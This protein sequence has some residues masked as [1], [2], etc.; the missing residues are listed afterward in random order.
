MAISAQ[1]QIVAEFS[2]SVTTACNLSTIQFTDKSTGNPTEWFWDFGNGTTSTEQNPKV[3]FLTAGTFDIKL[4]AKTTTSKGI[5]EKKDY[6]KISPSPDIDFD[7]SPD[8]GCVSL[9][10]LFTNYTQTNGSK[11]KTWTWDFG[12]GTSSNAQNPSHVYNTAGKFDIMLTAETMDGCVAKLNLKEGVKAGQPGKAQFSATPLNGCRSVPRHFSDASSGAI[13]SWNW[14]FGDGGTSTEQN[15]DYKYM[16]TGTFTVKL[17]VFNNGCADSLEY[18]DYMHII[19]P[20]AR[21][22][23]E[24]NCADPYN[25]SFK[26]RSVG[27][28]T[29]QWDFGDGTT[30]TVKNPTHRFSSTGSYAVTL[31]VSNDSCTDVIRDTVYVIDQSPQVQVSSSKT[32]FCRLDTITFFINNYDTALVRSYAWDFDDGEITGFGAFQDTITHVYKESGVYRPR[33]F[34]R[35]KMPCIDTIPVAAIIIHGPE[36]DFTFQDSVCLG[37]TTILKTQISTYNDEPIVKYAWEYGDGTTEEVANGPF[38]HT[39]DFPGKYAIKLNVTD[40]NGCEASAKD[41]ITIFEHPV[42]SA[43]VDTMV[44]VGQSIKLSASGADSYKWDNNAALSCLRCESPVATPQ[45]SGIFYVTGSNK[46][47]CKTSDSVFVTVIQKQEMVVKADANRICEGN[48]IQ[49]NAVGMDI[50]Q[51]TPNSYLSNASVS[52]PVATP[53]MSTTYTVIGSDKLS[54][55]FD[56]VSVFIKVDRVPSINIVDSVITIKP[57]NTKII[58]TR[59]SQ[60]V[61]TWTWTPPTGLSCTDCA[62][63][64]FSLENNIIYT[65]Q[66]ENAAGCTAKDSVNVY[67]FCTKNSLFI[68]NT[69]SPNGDGMNDVFYPRSNV[70]VTIKSMRVFNKWGQPVYE[71]IN[72][73]SNEPRFG[74][75]GTNGS[76]KATTD[77]YLYV[78]DVI[79]SNGL[80]IR[81]T[82]TVTLLQ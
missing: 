11:I 72:I 58:N 57:G 27:D 56:T 70:P 45:G 49:L 24:V 59:S 5:H 81:K 29:W 39:Y 54:C 9:N 47:G 43:G 71:K 16:D 19:P 53:L 2:A 33:L 61:T 10:V 64:E 48:S 38:V 44:C 12:D 50:Y 14:Y 79:C 30:T 8:S 82:G 51:W 77:V 28:K 78:I 69:F 74:W 17:K 62:E 68:P 55:F 7:L 25:V 15:P 67:M 66:V 41:N 32:T 73:S 22:T 35:D 20:V 52:S 76:Y 13:T 1:A 18:I 60:D 37:T 75:N 36:A 65:V 21:I 80:Q 6:I 4:I 63:P 31:V 3:D 46:A 34:L 26:N 23:K 40:I 42:V